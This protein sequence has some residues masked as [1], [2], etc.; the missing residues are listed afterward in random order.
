[1]FFLSSSGKGYSHSTLNDKR[2]SLAFASIPANLKPRGV[3][4]NDGK[5]PTGAILVPKLGLIIIWNAS[6]VGYASGLPYPGH[7]GAGWAS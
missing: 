3:F 4:R 5:K 2:R 6:C 7:V 1:M